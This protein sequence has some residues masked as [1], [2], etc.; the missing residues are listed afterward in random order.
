MYKNEFDANAFGF[1]SSP[2]YR[3]PR[4]VYYQP[5]VRVGFVVALFGA[6]ALHAI[7][8]HAI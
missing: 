2:Y 7:V 6:M 4:A 5:M 8:R 3:A 1:R